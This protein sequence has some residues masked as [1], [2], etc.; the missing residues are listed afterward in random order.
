CP[1]ACQPWSSNCNAGGVLPEPGMPSMRYRRLGANPPPRML[2][3]PFIPVAASGRGAVIFDRTGGRRES[4]KVYRIFLVS[5]FWSVRVAATESTK[6]ETR[7]TP[8][9]LL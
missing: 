8:F 4:L 7:V 2:S 6:G 9:D 5:C 3:K 1:P